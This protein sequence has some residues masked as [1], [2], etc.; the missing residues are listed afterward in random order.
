MGTK[1]KTSS[2]KNGHDPKLA[3]HAVSSQSAAAAKPA[4][5]VLPHPDLTIEE[6]R[7]AIE[8]ANDVVYT[9]DLEGDLTYTNA[10]ARRIFGFTKEETQRLNVREILDEKELAR[11]KAS[12]AAKL[13]GEPEIGRA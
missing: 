12:T 2:K 10:A 9:H 1:P 11:A 7:D 4:K 5:S 8:N 3:P 13:R 6:L